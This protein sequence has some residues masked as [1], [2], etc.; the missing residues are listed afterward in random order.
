MKRFLILI[1]SLLILS[2]FLYCNKQSGYFN[3]PFFRAPSGHIRADFIN[4]SPETIKSITSMKEITSSKITNLKSNA[5]EF[6]FIKYTGGEGLLDFVITFQSGK[7]LS[8]DDVYIEQGYH[9]TYIIYSDSI[10][11]AY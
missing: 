6:L 1:S 5:R 9:L 10:Y 11:V 8:S 7:T 3:I 2:G 4:K